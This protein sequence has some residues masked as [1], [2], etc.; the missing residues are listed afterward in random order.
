GEEMSDEHWQHDFA[1]SLMIFLNGHGIP[2]PSFKGDK[3][4]DDS[5]LLL[6]NAHNGSVDFKIPDGK[7]GCRWQKIIQT[8]VYKAS[9]KIVGPLDISTLPRHSI[10]VLMEQKDRE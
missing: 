6:F 8:A 1:K 5:F 4:R 10:S 7:Y 2:T 3:I 9:G